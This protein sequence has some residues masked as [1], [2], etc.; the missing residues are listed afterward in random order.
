MLHSAWPGGHALERIELG[1]A[2]LEQALLSE[3]RRKES[4][5]TVLCN[6]AI[7]D[8][9]LVAFSCSKLRPMVKGLFPRAEQEPVLALLEKSVVFLSPERIEA[10][11]RKASL[12]TA[13]VIANMYLRSIGASPISKEAPRAVGLSEETTCY[14][15]LEYFTEEDPFADFVVH[16]AAHVF[17]QYKTKDNRS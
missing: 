2:D 15:S 6:A 10:L 14:V 8:G 13:W 12:D 17:P 1:S 7:P 3:L 4:E 9:D 16:E 5:V 11:I